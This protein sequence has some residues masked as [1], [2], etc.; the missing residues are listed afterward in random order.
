MGR[1]QQF[2]PIRDF[3][4]QWS[5]AFKFERR[6]ASYGA[7]LKLRSSRDDRRELEASVC[8]ESDQQKIIKLNHAEDESE[9]KDG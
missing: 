6:V 1:S 8:E 7:A 9:V 2:P 3:K 5:Q 4:L